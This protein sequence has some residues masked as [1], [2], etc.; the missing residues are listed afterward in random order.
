VTTLQCIGQFCNSCKL[1]AS[2][3]I[4]SIDEIK[5]K[6]QSASLASNLDSTVS[7]IHSIDA[8]R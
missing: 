5:W 7:G 8:L 1:V 3:L 2:A 6:K 4:V